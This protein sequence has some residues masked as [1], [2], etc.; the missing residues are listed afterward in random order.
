MWFVLKSLTWIKLSSNDTLLQ[1]SSGESAGGGAGCLGDEDVGSGVGRAW[2]VA[3]QLSSLY[4]HE[5]ARAA[6]TSTSGDALRCGWQTGRH[7]RHQTSPSRLCQVRRHCCVYAQIAFSPCGVVNKYISFSLVVVVFFFRMWPRRRAATLRSDGELTD[8]S[9]TNT[10]WAAH[11]VYRWRAIWWRQRSIASC[12]ISSK[13]SQLLR[14]PTHPRI[15]FGSFPLA[16]SSFGT[17][18]SLSLLVV[19]PAIM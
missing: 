8:H 18:L 12:V 10:L 16:W 5:V 13:N 6:R 15:F 1:S 3:R 9:R 7:A 14:P 4:R 19:P 2:L 11:W 17:S